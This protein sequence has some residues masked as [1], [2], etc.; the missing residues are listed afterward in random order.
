MIRRD[1]RTIL[2]FFLAIFG[3]GISNLKNKILIMDRILLI[4]NHFKIF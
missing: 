2:G 1:G 4:L 3:N